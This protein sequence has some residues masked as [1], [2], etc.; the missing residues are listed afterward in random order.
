MKILFSV[1]LLIYSISQRI[2]VM[3]ALDNQ[4]TNVISLENTVPCIRNETVNGY[5][6]NRHINSFVPRLKCVKMMRTNLLLYLCIY[7]ISD[8]INVFKCV[9]FLLMNPAL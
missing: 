6:C 2:P 4:Y 9:V 8:S 1:L 3:K 7:V 5:G